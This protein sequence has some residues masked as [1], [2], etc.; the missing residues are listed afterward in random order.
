MDWPWARDQ[1]LS[2]MFQL[3]VLLFPSLKFWSWRKHQHHNFSLPSLLTQGA[4]HGPLRT[5]HPSDLKMAQLAGPE[6]RTVGISASLCKAGLVVSLWKNVGNIGLLGVPERGENK[7]ESPR[8]PRLIYHRSQHGLRT[9][10][11][12]FVTG[13]AVSGLTSYNPPVLPLSSSP[14]DF[15]ACLRPWRSPGPTASCLCPGAWA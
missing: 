15:F 7:E 14:A 11:C 1:P 10:T 9:W 13:L 4:Q 5:E 12:P 8:K 2:S 3:L 6:G